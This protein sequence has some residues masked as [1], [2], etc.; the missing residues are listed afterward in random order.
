ML[1]DIS[2]SH[3]IWL[4]P[5]PQEVYINPTNDWYIV[6]FKQTGFYRVNYDTTS[7]KKLINKLNNEGFRA[8]NVLNRAQIIDDLFN[9][10]RAN[11]VEYELL[12]SVTPYL[13][14]ETDHLPWKA[15]FN[16]LSYIHERFEQQTFQK[17]LNGYFLDLLSEMY[18]KVGFDDR[19]DDEHLDKLNREMILQWACKLNKAECIQKSVD[20]FA[21]WRNNSSTL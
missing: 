12:M 3:K 13:K 21:A 1:N 8:I 11:Y 10:A 18:D 15:F 19:D 2:L 9:L 14:R 16:S 7:W 17:E 4:G 20:L 6:N 5:E